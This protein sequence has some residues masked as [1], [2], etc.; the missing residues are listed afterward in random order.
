MVRV[1][2]FFCPT[3]RLL[4]NTRITGHV[5]M[6][7]RQVAFGD[8]VIGHIYTAI[9]YVSNQ[10]RN[11]TDLWTL[12][13]AGPNPALNGLLM[14]A[15][16]L[17]GT[18]TA[19]FRTACGKLQYMKPYSVQRCQHSRPTWSLADIE[20]IYNLPHKLFPARSPG[21]HFVTP[22]AVQLRIIID[23]LTKDSCRSLFYGTG[24]PQIE[25][26]CR[27]RLRHRAD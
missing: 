21:W 23:I 6:I 9:W 4:N 17:G 1:A 24:Y 14:Y 7:P 26:P 3:A 18:G 12:L 22:A 16:G 13:Q 15:N 5:F 10:F 8:K 25:N 19:A 27:W 2:G 20:Q 11:R